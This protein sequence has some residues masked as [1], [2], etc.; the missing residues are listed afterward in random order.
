MS[1]SAKVEPFDAAFQAKLRGLSLEDGLK[2]IAALVG[3][4]VDD[5]RACALTL[6]SVNPDL[7][8]GDLLLGLV[9]AIS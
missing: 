7:S 4:D 8:D 2:A 3:T 9:N 5:L 6:R 1:G